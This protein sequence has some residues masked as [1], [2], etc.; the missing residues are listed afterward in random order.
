MIEAWNT[1]AAEAGEALRRRFEA[2]EG[3]TPVTLPPPEPLGPPPSVEEALSRLDEAMTAAA[4]VPS[5]DEMIARLDRGAT[6][7]PGGVDTVAVDLAA[8]GEPLAVHVNPAWADRAP[9]SHL[10]E[11]LQHAFDDAHARAGEDRP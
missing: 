2:G 11:A 3:M 5:A 4:A 7:G 10:A 8:T 6:T 1:A 9:T